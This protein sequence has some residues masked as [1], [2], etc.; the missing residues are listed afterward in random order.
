[1]EAKLEAYTQDDI[2]QTAKISNFTY[3]YLREKCK[4]ETCSLKTKLSGLDPQANF[5]H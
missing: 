3:G 2:L 5:T 1:M 4:I